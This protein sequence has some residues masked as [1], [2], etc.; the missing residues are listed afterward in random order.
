MSAGLTDDFAVETTTPDP[1]PAPTPAPAASETPEATDAE[2]TD[3]A[4]ADASDETPA[5]EPTPDSDAGKQLAKRRRS[6]QDR[7]DEITREKYQTARERDALKAEREALKRELDALKAPKPA[8]QPST[9]PTHGP[10][11]DP[12]PTPDQFDSYE[13]FVK[14]QA[15]WEARQEFR[16]QQAAARAQAERQQDA[17]AERERAT[18]WQTRLA[19]TRHKTP[20]FDS[21]INPDLP[22]SEPMRDIVMDSEVGP[23]LLLY[24]SEHP[25]LAQRLST[26]HPIQVIREMGKL[27]ARLDA[28]HSGPA[29]AAKPTVSQAPAPIK[30]VA[31][32]PQTTD[33]LALSDDDSL[34]DHIRKMNA[35]ER[36]TR[37]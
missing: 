21:R 11:S 29:S 13:K 18:T 19:E 32:T 1:T 28:A 17:A 10:E 14:A 22:I 9:P 6:L 7:I 23:E 25:D 26:L 35:K 27:E 16:E 8:Q 12:E 30:P 33:P 4:A 5:K 15:R 2:P 20:D 36:A 34:D 24:L 37:R 31:G 3:E